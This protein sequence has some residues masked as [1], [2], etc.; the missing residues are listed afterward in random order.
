MMK[1]RSEL[2]ILLIQIREDK[3][4]IK[5]EITS[6]ADYAKVELSQITPLNVFEHQYFTPDILEQYDILFVGGASEAS[7]LEPQNYPFVES[8]KNILQF[9]AD[10]NFPTFASCFGFQAAVLA[11]GGEI[12]KDTQDFEM[13]TYAMNLSLVAKSDPVYKHVPNHFMAVS[14]HQEKALVCPE[15]CELLA[16]TKTCVHSFR[17]KQKN[18]WAFQFHP[19][20]DIERLTERLNAYKEKYTENSDHFENVIKSLEPTPYSNKLVGHFVD[21]I[22][23]II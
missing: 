20:L 9:A 15:N 5:E 10:S 2:R 22:L 19:E 17:V 4:V 16:D 8:I 1:K 23:E 6:F 12:I 3:N 21:Y 18:F 7:V 11:F 14:V 13:G